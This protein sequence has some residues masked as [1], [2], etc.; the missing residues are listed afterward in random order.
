MNTA[1][2]TSAGK[3]NARASLRATLTLAAAAVLT[4]RLAAASIPDDTSTPT[5]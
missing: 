3:H 4:V 2:N 1:S 5:T